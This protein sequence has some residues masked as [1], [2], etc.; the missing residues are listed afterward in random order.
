MTNSILKGCYFH[1][2]S[3]NVRDYDKSLA[4]YRA[5]GMPV[6][7]EFT[8]EAGGRHCFIDVGNGPYLE[9]HSSVEAELKE[10]RFQHFCLHVDDVDAAYRLA[11]AH[12]ATTKEAPFDY[13]LQCTSVVIHAR[14]CHVYGVDGESIELINWKNYDAREYQ[15]F[16]RPERS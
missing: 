2:V 4:F 15:K 12:G 13:D 16:M 10:S 14:I 6:F 7:Q 8:I 1:H 9:L 11:L 3:L 5:L